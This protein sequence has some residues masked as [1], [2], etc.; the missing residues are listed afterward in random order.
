MSL[1]ITAFCW[2][3]VSTVCV[4]SIVTQFQYYLCVEIKPIN[5]INI[6]NHKLE[7]IFADLWSWFKL[8]LNDHSCCWQ[9]VG[10]MTLTHRPCSTVSPMHVCHETELLHSLVTVIRYCT[11]CFCRRLPKMRACPVRSE[12]IVFTARRNCFNDVLS[13]GTILQI[14]KHMFTTGDSPL[15][16]SSTQPLGSALIALPTRRLM[17]VMMGRKNEK[18]TEIVT[19]WRQA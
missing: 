9:A 4:F 16:A 19:T 8:K 7:T 1:V 3:S 5:P 17:E 15:G 2:A 13:R 10:Y 6:C 11:S 12:R 14:K 18:D